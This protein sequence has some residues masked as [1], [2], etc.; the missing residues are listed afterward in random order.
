MRP[1][2]ALLFASA[3]LVSAC[4][5][6][7]PPAAPVQEPA[8][9][10]PVAVTATAA[11]A[12]APVVAPLPADSNPTVLT[13]EQR[14]RDRALA[15]Q[16]AAIVDAYSNAPSIFSSLVAD[17]SRNKKRVLYASNRDG[18]PEIY[19]GDTAKPGE[20]PLAITRGPERA[21]WA[22]FTRDDRFIL[23]TRDEG[24]DENWRIWRAAPDG[25]SP[26]L[27]TPGPK[28]HRDEPMLPRGKPKIMIYTTH[29]STSAASQLVVQ[30]IA[31]ERAEP[32]IVYE[33]PAPA[34]GADVTADGA[35]ALLLRWKSAS[36][37]VALEVETAGGKAAV[38]LYPP[39]GTKANV[40]AAAYSADG[41]LVY[42]ATDE[43]K[44]SF[45]LLAMDRKTFAVK[46]RWAVDEPKSAAI[47]GLAVS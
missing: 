11:P 35:R 1:I 10:P 25:S 13:E 9:P 32:K 30:P 36:D 20:A 21:I 43:G 17:L 37:L 2:A 40:S 39:E 42:L 33:D 46:A 19:A 44:E 24:A 45:A 22:S 41:K 8:P 34:F 7:P 29:V 31:G 26:T 18:V 12:P 6:T 28:Q 38:R 14:A 15:P 23:Y 16:V 3:L 47:G 5:E 4:E 27:L